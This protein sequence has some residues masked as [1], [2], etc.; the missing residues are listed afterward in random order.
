MS[1]SETTQPTMSEIDAQPAVHEFETPVSVVERPVEPAPEPA[2]PVEAAPVSAAPEVEAPEIELT[3]NEL[4]QK[5]G[6]LA[7]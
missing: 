6:F 4:A 2:A 1:D 5:R 3:A 7:A